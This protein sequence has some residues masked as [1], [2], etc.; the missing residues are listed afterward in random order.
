MGAMSDATPQSTTMLRIL[1]RIIKPQYAD[2]ELLLSKQ[3]GPEGGKG[4]THHVPA[5]E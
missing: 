1:T 2:F 4:D 5:N 3:G